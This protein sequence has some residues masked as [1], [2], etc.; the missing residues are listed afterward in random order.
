MTVAE[1]EKKFRD[2]SKFCLYMI[3]DDVTK[4]QRFLDELHENI[5]M[6]LSGVPYN[7]T[8]QSLRDSAL[9]VE[10]RALVRRPKRRQFEGTSSGAPS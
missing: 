3:P 7:T 9:D 4:M 1:Y 6:H 5:A 8:Y 10:R 2:L